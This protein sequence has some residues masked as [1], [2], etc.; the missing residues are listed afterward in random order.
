MEYQSPGSSLDYLLDLTNFLASGE[1]LSSITWTLES[2]LTKTGGQVDTTT[3]STIQVEADASSAGKA[4][5]LVAEAVT[6][7]GNTISRTWFIKV[8]EQIV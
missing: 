4:C 5:R 8:Q 1:T 3:G 2:G 7:A 6:N